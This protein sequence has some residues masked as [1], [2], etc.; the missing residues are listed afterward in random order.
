M[1]SACIR[2]PERDACGPQQSRHWNY[3][4]FLMTAC[5]IAYDGEIIGIAF[6]P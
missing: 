4:L 5:S 2:A 1:Y 3:S 6:D